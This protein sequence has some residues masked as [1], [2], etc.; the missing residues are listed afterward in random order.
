MDYFERKAAQRAQLVGPMWARIG[1]WCSLIML[2]T[3]VWGLANAVDQWHYVAAV[4]G[5]GFF[6]YTALLS[7]RILNYH[8]KR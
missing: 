4:I 2:A 8:K 3:C 6:A 5:V 7:W 1:L